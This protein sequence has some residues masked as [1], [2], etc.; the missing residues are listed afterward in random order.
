MRCC[1]WRILLLVA[2]SLSL[3]VTLAAQ[4]QQAAVPAMAHALRISAGDLLELAVFDTPEL[5]GKLR[6]S[7][8]GDVT[9]PVTGVVKVGGMTSEEAAAA[10]EQSFRSHDVLR[11]PHVS[12]FISEYATQ[13]VTVTGEVKNP[14]IYPLLGN[15]TILDL[16]SAAGGVSL[17]AGKDITVTHRIDPEHPEVLQI[18]NQPGSVAARLDIQ[19]GDTIAVSRAGVV[20]VVGDVAK[21]GGF[22]IDSNELT[23][24]QALALAQGVNK[25]AA[26]NKSRLIRKTAN[27]REEVDLPLKKII[28][29]KATDVP[30]RDGDIIF[31]PTDG[32]KNAIAR[33]TEAAIAVTTGMV[34]Y[35]RL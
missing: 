2:V 21:P 6:V 33:A 27:T 9:V 12:I 15:H 1:D 24:L 35:G 18:N 5:S 19:P 28:A 34:V 13:G 4:A 22:L 20:Y 8:V 25:T 17:R 11:E 26:Q 31:V 10:I 23:A 32:S 3:P 30:V 16:V 14:G 7:E 29:G